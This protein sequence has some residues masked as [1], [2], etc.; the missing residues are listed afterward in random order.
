MERE[1]EDDATGLIAARALGP[2]KARMLLQ[3]L[4]A[5]GVR[6]PAEAQTAFDRR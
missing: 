6:D 1:P 5:N 3:L 2:A 4:L